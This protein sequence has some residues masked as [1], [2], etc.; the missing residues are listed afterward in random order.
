MSEQLQIRIH[1]GAALPTLVYLPGL[2]GDWTLVASF[3]AR[4]AGR[5]RFVEF[6]YPRT[7]EWSLADYARAVDEALARN[8]IKHGW[9]LAESFGS[10]IA[11]AM[12]GATDARFKIEGLILAGGFVRHPLRWGV[13]LARCVGGR[14]SLS[15]LTRLLF[16]Y[17]RLARIRH[18]NAPETLA[19]LDEFIARRT[20]LDRRAAVHRLGLILGSDFRSVAH[21]TA[22]PVFALTGLLDPIVPWPPV[23]HWLRRHC[24]G[25]RGTRVIRQADHTVLATAP[26]LAAGQVLNW[27]TQVQPAGDCAARG[28]G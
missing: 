11:W 10:Q 15:L 21:T 20:D 13:R 6:I 5:V 28:S 14:M 4:V 19:S 3:R 23:L 17:A 12:L 26:R 1:G 22:I 9:L 18:R 16:F 8:G 7:V 24:P 27:M 25:L 2:H